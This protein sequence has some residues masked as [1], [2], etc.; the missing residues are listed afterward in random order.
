MKPEIGTYFEANVSFSQTRQVLEYK[1][2]KW[3]ISR[4]VFLRDLCGRRQMFDKIRS[5][6]PS[7]A[8]LSES[9]LKKKKTGMHYNGEMTALD[10][11]SDEAKLMVPFGFWTVCVCVCVEGMGVGVVTAI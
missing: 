6:H 8:S 7:S 10:V 2:L 1:G 3:K 4:R 11:L 9:A 5:I